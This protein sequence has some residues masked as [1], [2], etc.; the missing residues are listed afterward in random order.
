MELK[1]LKDINGDLIQDGDFIKK[2]KNTDIGE[3]QRGTV[4]W[5]ENEGCFKCGERVL[6]G[7][8]MCD[9]II[10]RNGKN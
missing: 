4:K 9:F 5:Y 6:I 2:V 1:T 8:Y 10:V 7:E 3:L